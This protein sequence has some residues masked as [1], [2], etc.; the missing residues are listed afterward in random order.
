[1]IK[2]QLVV[3]NSGSQD[4]KSTLGIPEHFLKLPLLS[5]E[6]L[7]QRLVHLVIMDHLVLFVGGR[8]ICIRSVRH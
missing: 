7:P 3:Q 6:S 8:R 4:L 1:M 2:K 5:K